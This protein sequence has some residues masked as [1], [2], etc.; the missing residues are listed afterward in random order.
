[1]R[2]ALRQKMRHHLQRCAI[3]SKGN[4]FMITIPLSMCN[5]IFGFLQQ[6]SL[7]N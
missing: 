4:R 3:V 7:Q 6:I 5:P 1:M 2:T